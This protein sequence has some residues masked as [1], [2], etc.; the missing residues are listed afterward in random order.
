MTIA[1]VTALTV[2]AAVDCL[3]LREGLRG[4][5]DTRLAL[6]FFGG[7][8]LFNILMIGLVFLVKRRRRG[9]PHAFL[10]GFEAVGGMVLLSY[11][12]IIAVFPD[13]G[14]DVLT[15]IIL[16]LNPLAGKAFPAGLVAVCAIVMAIATVPQL[17][18]VVLGGLLHR[19]YRAVVERRRAEIIS[20]E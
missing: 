2:L 1:D 5:S 8:P 14:G 19:R 12:G 4:N 20:A 7:L 10:A 18:V 17:V 16:P 3:V 13:E 9:A 6:F 11:L 15:A